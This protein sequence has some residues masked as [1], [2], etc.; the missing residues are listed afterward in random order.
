MHVSIDVS[1]ATVHMLSPAF[2]TLGFNK[3]VNFVALIASHEGR[4]IIIHSVTQEYDQGEYNIKYFSGANHKHC[5]EV[6]L[7]DLGVMLHTWDWIK[8][9][10]DNNGKIDLL[11]NVESARSCPN[12]SI[13]SRD[14]VLTIY[15]AREF[16]IIDNVLKTR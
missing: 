6:I 13:V 16:M 4:S 15:S 11:N 14:G 2:D 3:S 10:T 8:L 7:K 1:N 12:V 5:A 9:D